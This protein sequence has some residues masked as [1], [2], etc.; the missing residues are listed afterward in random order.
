MTEVSV[1][2]DQATG[3]DHGQ[4]SASAAGKSLIAYLGQLGL[5]DPS[6]MESLSMDCLYKARRRIASDAPDEEILRL[7]LEEVQRR[8]DN[9]I[10]QTLNLTSKEPH[11]IAAVRAALIMNGDS[12]DFL[13]RTEDNQADR[14][15]RVYATLPLATPPESPVVMEEQ[16]ISFFFS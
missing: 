9:A 2:M 10:T 13:F 1:V 15:A 14:I 4:A 8:F 6:L 12:S 16:P 3:I 11:K 5:K 7:A